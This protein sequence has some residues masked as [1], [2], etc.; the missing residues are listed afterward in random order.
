MIT[1]RSPYDGYP[2]AVPRVVLALV[3]LFDTGVVIMNQ[4]SA[5]LSAASHPMAP[6]WLVAPGGRP[7]LLLTVG[8]LIAVALFLF[9]RRPGA[10]WPGVA[11]LL[12]VGYLVEGHGAMLEGPQR[13]LFAGGVAMLG[14]V[15]SLA[16]AR[17]TGLDAVAGEV[18]A[19]YGAP[20][21]LAATYI[22]A[23]TSKMSTSGLEW[24][25][26]DALRSV[27]LTQHPLNRPQWAHQYA[28]LIA[29]HASIAG[30]LVVLTLIAQASAFFYAW[31][32]RNRAVSATLL[33]SFHANT[34]ILTPFFFPQTMSLLLALSFPWARGVAALRGRGPDP[35]YTEQPTVDRE[36]R[37]R[38]RK[39]MLLGAAALVAFAWLPSPITR[40]TRLH[41]RHG[42]GSAEPDQGPPRGHKRR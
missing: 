14:W 23:F 4:W 41:H 39:R 6:A 22:N 30:V 10:L 36:R 28:M 9:A 34:A 8:A 17:W 15:L 19:G 24:F 25:N 31:S 26:P 35:R 27:V 13:F 20:A 21:L 5:H 29:E 1:P 37:D 11:A 2:R 18:R 42:T 38:V 32:P 40:Y 33:L 7:W 3:M 16:Y 12:G